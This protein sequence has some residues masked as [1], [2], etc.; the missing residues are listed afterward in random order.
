MEDKLIRA[1]TRAGLMYNGL[2]AI[3]PF[4]SDAIVKHIHKEYEDV[5][6]YVTLREFIIIIRNWLNHRQDIFF[7]FKESCDEC[8]II[9]PQLYV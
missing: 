2:S 7:G 1:A 6:E 5:A 9:P 3:I 4:D 8:E